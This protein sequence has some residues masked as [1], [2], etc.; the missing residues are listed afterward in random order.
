MEK[1]RITITASYTPQMDELTGGDIELL[2]YG[3]RRTVKSIGFSDVEVLIEDPEDL[4]KNEE[5]RKKGVRK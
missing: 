4:K 5:A 2:R 1:Y 3:L